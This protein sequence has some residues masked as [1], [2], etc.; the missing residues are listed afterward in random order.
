VHTEWN[1]D[2]V[3]KLLDGC[4]QL[5]KRYAM[6]N[7]K[8]ISVPGAFEIPFAVKSFWETYQNKFE[9]PQVFITLGCV[10]RGDTPHFDYVCKAV[11]DGVLHLNLLLPVPTIFGVLT[12]DNRQQA[13][14]RTGGIHGNKGE[15][16]AISA[17]KMLAMKHS[18]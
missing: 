18:I 11:T 9:K 7:Y 6:N 10:L 1:A 14:D 17:L 5:L 8:V 12:V 2:I 4:I 3:D 16:A 15:E 13:D